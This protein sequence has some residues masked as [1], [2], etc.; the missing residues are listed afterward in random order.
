MPT[1]LRLGGAVALTAAVA[2]AQPGNEIIFVGTST[3]GSTDAH[4]FVESGTGNSTGA[5]SSFTDNV[6]GAVWADSGR[7]LYVGQGLQNRVARGSWDGTGVTW[8]TLWSA[9]GACYGVE[10]DPIRR[11]LWT[12]TGSSG[13]NRELHCIDADPSSA[14]YGTVI[15]QTNVLGTTS[16]ERWSISP[17]GNLAAVPAAFIG[18]GLFEI[19]DLEPTSPNYL[20][21]VVSTF[22]PGLSGLLI[23]SDLAISFDEQYAY[24]LY[25][26]LSGSVVVGGLAVLHIP[27]VTW[28]DFDAGL[29]GPQ[30]LAFTNPVPN[31]MDLSFDSSFAVV[32]GQGGAGWLVRVDFDYQN[33][34]NT[35]TTE[36]LAGQGVLPNCNAVSLSPDDQRIAVSA[37]PVNLSSPSALVVVDANTG[38]LLQNVTLN[39][40]WNVY[41]TAW[42]DRSPIAT[43]ESFGSGCVGS[44]GIPELA[45]QPGSRPALGSTF[46]A[47]VSNLPSNVAIMTTGFSN[48]WNSSTAT[49]LPLPLD[50]FGMAGC[51]Q[52]ADPVAVQFLF[53]AGGNASWS[54]TLPTSEVWF[55]A[56][57]Y[58]QAFVLDS[59]ANQLGLTATNGGA[60][61]LGY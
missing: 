40:A 16:R 25:T 30:P 17:L 60:G 7:N 52:L 18:S 36:F 20:Q 35:T 24:L 57:F 26:G 2:L 43:Y 53:G 21:V 54:W 59:A 5:N 27:T 23:A 28:L 10:H 61:V 13:A 42:Q 49:P 31:R 46:Q 11:R 51:T 6:T 8:S 39:P 1:P 50:T 19:V 12:L 33:P 44:L 45:A 41:T 32:S 37:T 9:P 14:N 15:D 56:P 29:P 48:T 22:V 47:T 38:T 34:A 3:S 55:G 4:H 58:Q